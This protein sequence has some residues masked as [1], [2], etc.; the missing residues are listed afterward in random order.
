MFR[1][2]LPFLVLAVAFLCSSPRL[3][4]DDWQP[5]NPEELKMTADPAHPADAIMLYHEEIADDM[6]RH[7][8]IYK[9]VKI[10]TEKG[11]D[12]ANVQIFYDGTTVGISEIKA[13]T[14]SPDGTITPFTDKALNSTYVKGH[15]TRYLVKTFSMPNV[16]VGSIIE[17]KYTEFWDEWLFAPNWDVQEDLPQKRAKFAFIPFQIGANTVIQDEHGDIKNRVYYSFIGLPSTTTLK[18]VGGNNRMELELNDIPAYEEED[19]APPEDVTKMRVN[20]YYGDNNMAKPAQFWKDQG[21]WWNKDVESFAGHTPIA[22]HSAAITAAVKQVVSD[23]DTAEQKARKIYAYVQ[24]IKNLNY[25]SGESRLQELVDARSKTKRTVDDVLRNNEGHRNEIARLYWAMARSANLTAYM[26][27]VADREEVF[28]QSTV[29]NP[30]QLTVELVVVVLDGKEVFLDPGTPFCPFGHLAWQ[31]NTTQGIRQYSDG[32][33]VLAVTPKA[34]YKEAISKRVGHIQLNDDGSATGKVGVAWAG[35]DALVH[36]L[37]GLRTDDAG[38]K[39]ELE[40]ELRA[41]LPNGSSV[42]LDQTKGWEDGESQ[43][44]ASFT[45]MIPSYASNTGKRMIVPTNLFE[46]RERQP[47][48]H[49]ERKQSVYFKYPFYV[50]DDTQIT[51][52]ASFHIENFAKDIQP[53]TTDFSVYK[54][55]RTT[56]GNIVTVSRDFAMG[57]IAFV[58]KDY[59]AL[60]KFYEDVDTQDAEPLVLGAQ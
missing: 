48:A 55:K 51:F 25:V 9:R 40:D 14:I 52:P 11:K 4:A 43:L 44:T 42:Q 57:G 33:I 10:L 50:M 26:M 30:S 1:A 8:Y 60:R 16:Q 15:N 23:S 29:P 39:K 32:S 38:K 36:R 22:D 54:V 24:K 56:N 5:I 2:K 31:H 37:R 28:F 19:F 58:A 41:L 21:K 13:R 53:I 17:W 49:G 7:R 12:R 3:F 45:I 6:T 46:T 18:T 20:F 59:P 27:R 47:F 35:E 34:D